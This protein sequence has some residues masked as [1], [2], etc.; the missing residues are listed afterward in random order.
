MRRR[1]YAKSKRVSK[2]LR[3]RAQLDVTKVMSSASRVVNLGS[4]IART[5]VQQKANLDLALRD[6]TLAGRPH[7]AAPSRT[8]LRFLP[9]VRRKKARQ[10]RR[11]RTALGATP[12]T[13]R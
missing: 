12:R 4:S 2:I 3:K 1:R 10:V 8:T 5:A 11:V 6:A 9:R 7:P 13:L